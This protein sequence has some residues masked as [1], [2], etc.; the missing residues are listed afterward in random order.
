MAASDP[1]PAMVPALPH[2]VPVVGM[3]RLRRLL[4]IA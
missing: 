1:I 3:P 2:S 4:P